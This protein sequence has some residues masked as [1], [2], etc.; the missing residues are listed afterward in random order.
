MQKVAEASSILL[1]WFSKNYMFA[2]PDK[3]HL[4]NTT[5]KEGSV[6]IENEIIKNS[7]QE[8]RLGIVLDNKLTFEPQ[9]ASLCKKTRQKLHAL[10]RI[11]NYM[12]IRKRS[13][14]NAF[15]LS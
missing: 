9:V 7:L 12:D 13:I 10:A 1:K 2:N 5:S 15:I 14:K 4:L 6:K 8:K 3:C 11:A